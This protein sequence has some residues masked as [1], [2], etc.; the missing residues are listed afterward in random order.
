[1]ARFWVF[2]QGPAKVERLVPLLPFSKEAA[3]LPRLRKTLAAYRL[4]FGQP[5]QEE[6]IEFRGADRS[7]AELLLLASRLRIDL[8]PPPLSQQALPELDRSS[9]PRPAQ[10]R[11]QPDASNGVGA[12]N[13]VLYLP[14][15]PQARTHAL[16]CPW[17]TGDVDLPYEIVDVSVVP[18]DA[19]RCTRCGGGPARPGGPPLGLA[20][21]CAFAP[22]TDPTT[23][24]RRSRLPHVLDR[25]RREMKGSA[26]SGC[27]ASPPAQ[28]AG[29]RAQRRWNYSH[30]V[31]LRL[32]AQTQLL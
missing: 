30:H 22:P 31:C 29:G 18:I 10:T 20:A 7:D 24:G 26:T 17:A 25:L 1:M 27:A 28:R 19:P 4:A 11:P 2:D 9:A 23:F 14:G 5:R 12:A 8:S 3:A 21:R 32:I 13:K 16:N 6:L 15:N